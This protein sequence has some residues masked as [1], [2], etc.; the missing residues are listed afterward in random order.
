MGAP[1]L[2]SDFKAVI[3]DPTSSLCGN[4]INTLLKLP[5]LIW[6]LVN[7]MFDG[8]GNPTKEF[9]SSIVRTG[10]LIFSASNTETT[11]RLLCDGREVDR[12]VYAN[13]FAIIGTAYGIPSGPSVFKLPDYRA[14]FPVGVGTFEGGNS[15]TFAVEG[16]EDL[17]T[18]SI[19]E[20][21]KH[22]HWVV[23][24]DEQHSGD[25]K[26][27]VTDQQ[28]L[29]RFIIGSGGDFWFKALGSDTDATIAQT[30]QTGGA[31]STA[32]PQVGGHNCLPPY[33]PCYILI[34]T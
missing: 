17:H 19:S 22:R 28:S 23:N 16:G 9:L 24:T 5:V 10:D 15:A 7:W 3:S 30:S 11:G 29:Y 34:A 4:F 26:P 31:D 13:L 6:Q 21:P 27:F 8:S 14:R 25:G 33:L 2:P 20:M 1:V 32:S 18:L 12:T